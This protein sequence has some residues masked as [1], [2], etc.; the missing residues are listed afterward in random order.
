MAS[1]DFT[2]DKQEYQSVFKVFDKDNTG[3]ITIQQVNYYINKF[4]QAQHGLSGS[5]NATDTEKGKT[6]SDLAQGTGDKHHATGPTANANGAPS[7]YSKPGRMLQTGSLQNGYSN[8]Q[9]YNKA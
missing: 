4:E 5:G 9:A 7:H 8:G 3:E 2:I 1:N 6:N